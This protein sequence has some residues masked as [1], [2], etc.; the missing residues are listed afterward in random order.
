MGMAYI[1]DHLSMALLNSLLGT[2]FSPIDTVLVSRLPF[3]N[4]SAV[5]KQIFCY[6]WTALDFCWNF[7]FFASN[8]GFN[9]EDNCCQSQELEKSIKD[10]LLKG[11]LSIRFWQVYHK[12]LWT[13]NIYARVILFTFH[14]FLK[15]M[16]EI[17]GCGSSMSTAYTQV[18][19]VLHWSKNKKGRYLNAMYHKH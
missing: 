13:N 18:F 9:N 3:V 11:I 16:L 2:S 10:M 8:V 6:N 4:Y 14:F 12:W 7:N 5:I 17:W 19:T 15:I 1:Q